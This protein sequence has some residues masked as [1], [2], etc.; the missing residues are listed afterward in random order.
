ME[1]STF[2]T[3][4]E[5][6]SEIV[7]CKDRIEKLESHRKSHGIQIVNHYGPDRERYI[8]KVVLQLVGDDSEERNEAFQLFLDTLLTLED[9]ELERLEKEFEEL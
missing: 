3:G 7:Q 2:N 5:L 8:N 9:K 4:K 1:E 6:Q